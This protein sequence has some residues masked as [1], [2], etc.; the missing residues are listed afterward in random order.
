MTQLSNRNNIESHS[1]MR[2][3]IVSGN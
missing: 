3:T 2:N 1:A